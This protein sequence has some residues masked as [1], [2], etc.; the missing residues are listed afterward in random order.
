[1]PQLPLAEP[2]VFQGPAPNPFIPAPQVGQGEINLGHT[3]NQM[4][5]Q[6]LG[7]GLQQQAVLDD[8]LRIRR[9][10]ELAEA[11][12]IDLENFQ[13]T[14]F[15]NMTAPPTG[16]ASPLFDTMAKA[17]KDQRAIYDKYVGQADKDGVSRE[18]Y[19]F[20]DPLFRQ[21][22]DALATAISRQKLEAAKDN[23]YTTRQQLQT[24]VM[25]AMQQ[26]A[27]SDLG[28][29]E[30]EKAGYG[31]SSG[32]ET[33]WGQHEQ[34]LQTYLQRGV[35]SAS[36]AESYR[37]NFGQDF[38]AP[39][40][41]ASADLFAEKEEPGKPGRSWWAAEIRK[42]LS[43]PSSDM[44][45]AFSHMARA[46]VVV[47]PSKLAKLA[48]NAVTNRLKLEQDAEADAQRRS[49]AQDKLKADDA[50]TYFHRI[51]GE[52]D[53]DLQAQMIRKV[54]QQ[55]GP[56]TLE[57]GS[58][59]APVLRAWQQTLEAIRNPRT[60]SDDRAYAAYMARANANPW[61]KTLSQDLLAA[62]GDTLTGHDAGGI[63]NHAQSLR[64][65]LTQ[66][67]HTQLRD[68]IADAKAAMS[69]KGNTGEVGMVGELLAQFEDGIWK[70]YSQRPKGQSLRE[71]VAAQRQEF[72]PKIV[73]SVVRSAH[74]ILERKG[75]KSTSAMAIDIG[76]I[77]MK[78]LP[79][80]YDIV[81]A[82]LSTFSQEYQ[83]LY[84]PP[85]APIAPPSPPAEDTQGILDRIMNSLSGPPKPASPAAPPTSKFGGG[86]NGRATPAPKE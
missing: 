5:L 35:I 2:R 67:T 62:T 38:L 10:H 22:H 27:N 58:Q 46:G 65:T 29:T 73:E 33:I 84:P 3:L 63:M 77:A 44:G 18:F 32:I 45:R 76:K 40:M 50:Y 71:Y 34:L 36:E 19:R 52:P 64:H 4:G 69:V 61:D 53:Q 79:N 42:G 14:T 55:F 25:T 41:E 37:K 17:P 81:N 6:A 75:I 13:G 28:S 7:H 66:D 49:E 12:D 85:P 11:M 56:G 30:A 23:F 59:Q 31:F 21:R 1:M 20:A 15:S 39:V 43:D 60:K 68:A 51:L 54:E 16:M 74:D 9:A 47:D 8:E 57:Y 78:L 80:E 48:Q 26:I 82:A 72:R 70:G 83:A 86:F 24:Q